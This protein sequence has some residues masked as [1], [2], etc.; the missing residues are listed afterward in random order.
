MG[1]HLSTYRHWFCLSGRVWLSNCIILLS[2]IPVYAQQDST[3]RLETQLITDS[4][5]RNFHTQTEF[6]R[7]EKDSSG[8]FGQNG[9]SVEA[10]LRQSPGLYVRDYGGH[11]GLKTVSLRGFAANQTS[12]SILGIP[13]QNTSTQ[14]VNFGNFLLE[15][16]DAISVHPQA[17]AG[18]QPASGG[19]VDLEIGKLSRRKLNLLLGAGSY[20]EKIAGAS[21]ALPMGRLETQTHFN[22]IQAADDYP[23]R[24]NGEEGR[25]QN[26]GFESL[27][28]QTYWGYKR[29][30]WQLRYLGT[31]FNNR[32]G[33]PAAVV[34]G[35][36]LFA[37]DSLRQSDVFQTLQ[38][39]YFPQKQNK[40]VPTKLNLSAAWHYNYLDALSLGQADFYR[41]NHALAQIR[42]LHLGLRNK[43]ETTFRIQ[44][45]HL[46]SDNLAIRF[47]PV[48]QVDRFEYFWGGQHDRR[49]QK[50]KWST[51][52]GL[53]YVPQMGLM[54]QA[55]QAWVWEDSWKR[56]EKKG[57]FA[58]A[59]FSHLNRGVRLPAF[60]ELYYFGYGNADL[61]AE[62]TLSGDA[63]VRLE[64][65][66]TF[67]FVLKINLFANLTQNKI[68]A[69]P[70][71]PVRWSTQAVGLAGTQGFELSLE[72]RPL[73]RHSF[74]FNYTLQKA[75]D[76]SRPD[77]PLLPYTPCELFNAG[78]HFRHRSCYFHLNAHYSGWRFNSLNNNR[79]AFMPA[80]LLLDTGLGYTLS[81]GSL[82]LE[83]ELQL[84]NLTDSRYAVV[85]S[86]PMPGRI[87]GGKVR[88]K[89]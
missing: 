45:A 34:T 17:E 11:G 3:F 43:L 47:V 61:K 40:F 44:Y 58:Y 38:F 8:G 75:R 89:W 19:N 41:L 85:Q 18:R 67:P 78:Y 6:L 69:I 74:A 23:F 79:L 13:Y 64:Q 77:R 59:F 60:H 7:Y 72:V 35:Q 37:A 51:G 68:I 50:S 42:L 82:K 31:G 87:W 39:Q 27:H 2:L 14:V 88:V 54:W 30:N 62:K 10:V 16:F 86:Y 55:S 29:A 9:H 66:T 52:L 76:L 56:A 28:V 48:P 20:G 70:L 65:K 83:Y 25:R 4:L 71:S 24:I 80:Y 63:G 36:P 57:E 33:V 84:S 49:G 81:L 5:W 22:F 15:D 21:V 26:A 73:A 53:Q 32:Q 46:R 1:A 12:A